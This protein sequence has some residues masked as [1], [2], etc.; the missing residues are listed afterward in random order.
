MD[1]DIRTMRKY[2]SHE[3]LFTVGCGAIIVI[4][5]GRYWII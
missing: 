5:S 3:T 1:D 2:I 4:G